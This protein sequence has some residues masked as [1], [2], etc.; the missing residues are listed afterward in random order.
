MWT[1]LNVSFSLVICLGFALTLGGGGFVNIP[2]EY[3]V[4]RICYAIAFVILLIRAGHWLAF[5]RPEWGAWIGII[6]AFVIFGSVGALWILSNIWVTE[7]EH[8]TVTVV[9]KSEIPSNQSKQATASF[10]IADCAFDIIFEFPEDGLQR[11]RNAFNNNIET[12]TLH[13]IVNM[14][15]Q[16]RPEQV[17]RLLFV[18]KWKDTTGFI[19]GPLEDLTTFVPSQHDIRFLYKKPTIEFADPAMT[20]LSSGKEYEMEL[21]AS[22]M[23]SGAPLVPRQVNIRTHEGVVYSITKFSKLDKGWSQTKFSF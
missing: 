7:R 16:S 19:T 2:Y 9:K 21:T 1:V 22:P 10:L 15:E 8:K 4:A 3:T 17:I 12:G 13:A 20:R 18:G 14:R 23:W 11:F 5:E 6:C